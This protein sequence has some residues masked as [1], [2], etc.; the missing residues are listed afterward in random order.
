[1]SQI[2]LSCF[3]IFDQD[4]LD[5][6]LYKI[7]NCSMYYY[8]FPGKVMP[9]QY[10]LSELSLNLLFIAL[11]WLSSQLASRVLKAT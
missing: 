11:V 1:M 6:L 2:I 4:I 10:N 8:L 9:S 3:L 7:K 5:I